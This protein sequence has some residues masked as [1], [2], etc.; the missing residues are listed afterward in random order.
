MA[1][2]K[3]DVERL[4]VDL[5][6]K[7]APARKQMARTTVAVEGMTCGACT[8]AIEGGFKGLD[9]VDTFTVSLITERA[10]AIHDVSKVSAEKIAEM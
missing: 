2:E 5:E 7:D 3:D 10:V 6:D 1:R 8:A 9:G 4:L